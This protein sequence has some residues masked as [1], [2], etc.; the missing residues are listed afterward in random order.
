MGAAFGDLEL[1]RL[2]VVYPGAVRYTLRPK[3]EVMP[4]AQCV[5]ELT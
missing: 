4:L 1:T 2:L 5:A 3:I